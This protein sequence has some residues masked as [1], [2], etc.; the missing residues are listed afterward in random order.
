MHRRPSELQIMYQRNFLVAML[1]VLSSI[2]APIT[3]FIFNLNSGNTIAA[4]SCILPEAIQQIATKPVQNSNSH[5]S[6]LPQGAPISGYIGERLRIVPEHISTQPIVTPGRY[7]PSTADSGVFSF[8]VIEGAG[9]GVF[10]DD[11]DDIFV[12]VV[13]DNIPIVLDRSARVCTEK[14]RQPTYPLVAID[15]RK[16]G[17]VSFVIQIDTSGEL[18]PFSVQTLTSDSDN[19]SLEIYTNGTDDDLL[20][21]FLCEEPKGWFFQKMV[22]DVIFKWTY[23]PAI[24]NGVLATTFHM[25]T[26]NFCLTE[27]CGRLSF[28]PISP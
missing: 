5:Y 24:V 4:K 2:V 1:L 20:V 13:E 22:E 27:N 19:V 14:Y 11:I 25:V 23:E 7:V 18:A 12:I 21:L 3:V 28:T 8:S 26:Y 9:V 16:E 6:L 15:S 17:V 10:T